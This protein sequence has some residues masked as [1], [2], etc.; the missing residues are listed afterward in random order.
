MGDHFDDSEGFFDTLH[1]V[2]DERNRGAKR[3]GLFGSRAAGTHKPGESDTDIMVEKDGIN[4]KGEYEYRK[5][6]KLHIVRTPPTIE[7][8]DPNSR[9]LKD[10]KEKTHWLTGR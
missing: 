8:D 4:P 6:G 5:G 7:G 3:V 1:T 2:R 9:A 10:M